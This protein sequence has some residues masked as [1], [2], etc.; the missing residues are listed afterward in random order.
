MSGWKASISTNDQLHWLVQAFDIGAPAKLRFR[1]PEARLLPPP[2]QS[3]RP[4]ATASP[5]VRPRTMPASMLSPA[6]T[7][8]LAS[9]GTAAKRSHSSRGHQQCTLRA[10]RQHDDLAAALLDYFAR[11]FFLLERGADFSSYQIL[12]LPQARLQ[13]VDPVAGLLQRG[14]GG[15][16][17]QSL[18]Q[19]LRE[20][21][22]SGIEIV[23]RRRAADCRWRRCKSPLPPVTDSWSRQRS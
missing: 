11:G 20:P 23:R 18:A 8:L 14:A 4:R 3:A 19:L 6:P 17:H 10:K 5:R 22:H 21:S 9:T 15:I 7:V 1:H 2:C 13:Q 16:Q 12:Q